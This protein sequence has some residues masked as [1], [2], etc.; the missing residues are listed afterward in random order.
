MPASAAYSGKDPG[1]GPDDFSRSVRKEVERICSITLGRRF[2]RIPSGSNPPDAVVSV[3]V[4]GTGLR[5]GPYQGPGGKVGHAVSGAMVRGTMAL[6]PVTGGEADLPPLERKFRGT[7]QPPQS[8][9]EHRAW[10]GPPFVEALG[11]ADIQVV[12]KGLLKKVQ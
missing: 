3:E 12:L 6:Q 2:R 10:G 8:M 7:V 11:K 5:G 9:V 4:H 1:R